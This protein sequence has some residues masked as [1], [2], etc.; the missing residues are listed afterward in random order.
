M[1]EYTAEGLVEYVQE[2]LKTTKTRYAW[3]GL[4]RISTSGYVDMLAALYPSKYTAARK[5]LLKDEIGKVYLCDCVGMIK[6]YY[7]GGVGSPLYDISNDLNTTGFYSTATEK[8]DIDTLPEI[9]GIVLYM[10]GH[11]GVYIGNGQCV[12]CT[13]GK[14]GDGIVK[15]AVKD[16]GWTHWLKIKQID[17]PDPEKIH[18]T[19]TIKDEDGDTETWQGNLLSKD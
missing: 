11:V 9:P 15:T 14:Y 2:L 16:R 8:G 18:V 7:F 5:Q 4:M 6:S 3:G 13:L 17:Y 10:D 12:E 19:V 1:K